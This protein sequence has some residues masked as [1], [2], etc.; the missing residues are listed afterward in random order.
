[1]PGGPGE[2]GFDPSL[3]ALAE[4]LV[5]DKAEAIL[6]KQDQLSASQTLRVDTL[7]SL[8]PA[9]PAIPNSPQ[10]DVARAQPSTALP[11]RDERV[12]AMI[13]QRRARLGDGQPLPEPFRLRR[14]DHR[15]DIAIAR[16]GSEET[17]Q[18]VRAG[19]LWLADHQQPDGRWDAGQT[20]GGIESKVLG[21]D[22]GGAGADAD[23]GITG[24]ALL[25]FLAAGHTHLEGDY[26]KEVEKGLDYLIQKQAA[27]GNLSGDARLFARMYCHGMALFALSEA[28]GMTGDHR[29]EEAVISGINYSIRSQHTSSGGWRYQPGDQ[30][31]MSQ[32]GWQVMALKSAE[33]AG[34]AIP[35]ET[36]NLM[37]KFLASCCRGEFEGLAAY[38]PGEQISPTM[39]A[40]ALVSRMLM[41][42]ELNA[43]LIREAQGEIARGAHLESTQTQT[44]S[45]PT[46][47]G[48][49]QS[50]TMQSGSHN[51]LRN[52][53]SDRDANLRT[54][55]STRVSAASAQPVTQEPLNLYFLYYGT[56]AMYL[57]QDQGWEEWN[58]YMQGELLAAQQRSGPHVGSWK[59]DTI[60]GTYGGRVYSTAMATL[61]LEVYYRYLPL[62]RAAEVARQDDAEFRR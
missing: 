50:A 32:F 61:S 52:G 22:R 51:P 29:L 54:N 27:D 4:S 20:G 31:D 13:Q 14:A 5:T 56:L 34:I 18:A 45:S 47:D 3:Q 48:L 57:A 39:T 17:E 49:S 19:L 11:T 12:D 7:P 25:A 2:L 40:E 53:L 16:G 8:P 9:T 15:L 37:H 35:N 21:H 30:G 42:A 28:Y 55:G 1:M 38:R 41:K 44:A 59:P 60:W 6:D 10:P 23:T 46:S 43:S 36:R 24:L 26:R 58:R 62:Y 33:L